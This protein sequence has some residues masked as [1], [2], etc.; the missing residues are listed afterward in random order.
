MKDRKDKRRQSL[1]LCCADI[2]LKENKNKINKEES[3]GG[4][5]DGSGSGIISSSTRRDGL[6]SEIFGERS[7]RSS[8]FLC[9]S[10]I[11]GSSSPPMSPLA[12]KPDDSFGLSPK[13]GAL[14]VMVPPGEDVKNQKVK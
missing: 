5:D 10:Q 2:N 13:Q 7:G 3:G 8:V 9:C 1:M 6:F 11:Q 12:P 4:H 14:S